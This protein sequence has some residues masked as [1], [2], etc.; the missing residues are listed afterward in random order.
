M[1]S[2]GLGPDFNRS[3]LDRASKAARLTAAATWRY[4]EEPR[5]DPRARFWRPRLVKATNK[6][7]KREQK[8]DSKL[9][10]PALQVAPTTSRS[11]SQDA[12]LLSALPAT[13]RATINEN[14]F[15]QDEPIDFSHYFRSLDF[16][17]DLRTEHGLS[18]FTAWRNAL[19]SHAW[20]IRSLTLKHW[21][22][23]WGFGVN[24]WT[25]S[26][27]KTHFSR[28]ASGELA[29]SRALSTPVHE[30]CKC[31][32]EQLLAQQDATFDLQNF[33]AAPTMLRFINCLRAGDKEV[34]RPTLV[35]AARIFAELLQEHSRKLSKY[36]GLAGDQ[37]VKCNMPS[38][39]LCGHLSTIEEGN[40][41]DVVFDA[42][43][44]S[45]PSRTSVILSVS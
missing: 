41:S 4:S 11:R 39:F 43:A 28:G 40:G 35:D 10:D 14:V 27:D 45:K 16:E 34:D 24:S 38:L 22:S 8:T 33:R 36:H 44:T 17:F 15:V 3:Y 23:W 26:E 32:M 37:C 9:F 7:T 21:T 12:Q 6:Q 1:S 2:D 42:R 31:S 5:R 20:S 30:T 13:I 25:S 29:I 19:G 18:E